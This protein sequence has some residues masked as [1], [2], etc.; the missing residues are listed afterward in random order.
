VLKFIVAPSRSQ[1][2]FQV[3][4]SRSRA[5]VHCCA[6]EVASSSSLSRRQ[7]RKLIFKS[8]RRGRTLSSLS[9]RQA[10]CHVTIFSAGQQIPLTRRNLFHG[11]ANSI[12]TPP[13][14]PRAGESHC[15][16]AIFSVGRQTQSFQLASAFHC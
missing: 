7:G 5:Q 12:A 4:P 8:R 10:H 16:A 3:A 11:P 6:V 14:F 2:H 9:R 13:S 15:H 1:A